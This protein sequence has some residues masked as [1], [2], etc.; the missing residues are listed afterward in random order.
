[1]CHNKSLLPGNR[2]P[3]HHPHGMRA[4]FVSLHCGYHPHVRLPPSFHRQI[5]TF[6]LR[7][8][9][10]FWLDSLEQR[11]RSERIERSNSRMQLTKYSSIKYS[12]FKKINDR[13]GALWETERETTP[14]GDAERDDATGRTPRCGRAGSKYLTRENRAKI[15]WDKV[16]G[17][18]LLRCLIRPSLRYEKHRSFLFRRVDLLNRPD[19]GEAVR[20]VEYML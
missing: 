1:M 18:E 5:S 19:P 17:S 4:S 11:K 6:E 14:Q 9:I 13:S 16:W 7:S 3:R 12:N 20:N 10:A 15:L 2:E 8:R